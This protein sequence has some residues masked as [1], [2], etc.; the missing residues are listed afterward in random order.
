[1][2]ADFEKIGPFVSK[3]Y[4]IKGTLK[5][6]YVNLEDSIG[7]SLISNDNIIDVDLFKYINKVTVSCNEDASLLIIDGINTKKKML[8]I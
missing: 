2:N 4:E 1:M 3:S 5:N 7:V 6:D 8:I